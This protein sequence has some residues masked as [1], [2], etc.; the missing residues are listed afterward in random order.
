VTDPSQRLVGIVVVSH[1]QRLADGVREVAAQMAGPEVRL[2][3]V[4]GAPDGSLGTDAPRVAEAIGW[5]DARAGVVV[6]G[7]L[8]SAIMASHTAAEM[9]DP[10]LAARVRVSGG[11]VTE[12]AVLAAVEASIGGSLEEVLGAADRARELDKGAGA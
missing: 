9:L 3:A 2:A 10:D 1:S 7:D 8:G 11:P 5:A 6:L 12:G 4:G